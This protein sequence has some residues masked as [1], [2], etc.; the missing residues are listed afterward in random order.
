MVA[1]CTLSSDAVFN[2][3]QYAIDESV[4]KVFYFVLTDTLSAK[5]RDLIEI[6]TKLTVASYNSG[7][8]SDSFSNA[9]VS[10]AS[11]SNTSVEKLATATQHIRHSQKKLLQQS[12]QLVYSIKVWCPTRLLASKVFSAATRAQMEPVIIVG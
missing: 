2:E 10:N 9:S 5:Q 8:R 11:V 7:G 1:D 6:V 3:E 12:N 4:Q